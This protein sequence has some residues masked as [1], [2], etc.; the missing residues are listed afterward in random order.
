MIDIEISDKSIYKKAD[1]FSLFRD[2]C[3]KY[4]GDVQMNFDKFTVVE[5]DSYIGYIS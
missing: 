5:H 2:T 4:L 1:A 3:K